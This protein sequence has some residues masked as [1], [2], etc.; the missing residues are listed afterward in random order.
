[1]KLILPSVKFLGMALLMFLVSITMVACGGG[2]GD[3]PDGIIQYTGL[4]S[5][6]LITAGNAEELAT[7]AYLGGYGPA[8][9]TVLD[10]STKPAGGY[11]VLLYLY[12]F[13]ADSV[14]QA[15]QAGAPGVRALELIDDVELSTCPG[16]TGSLAYSLQVNDGTGAFTGSF[17]FYDYCD[18][19][20]TFSG[21]ITVSGV[22][23]IFNIQFTSLS[24]DLFEFTMEI[25]GESYTLDGYV[26]SMLVSPT[27]LEL[28]IDLLLIDGSTDTVYWVNDFFLS[29]T[30]EVFY[31]E[32]EV[33]GTFY[34]PLD[35]YVEL[36]TP[37]PMRFY[38]W[39]N[40]P[41]E[42]TIILSGDEFTSAML[43][44]V[45]S[46]SFIVYADLDGNGSYEW[47][48]GVKFW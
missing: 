10:G 8:Q 2:G 35:G 47:D 15:Y 23:D 34:S 22:F 48:S 21:A 6:A 20:V 45:S 24:L 26:D 16:S 30:E 13:L 11:P 39:D 32:V 14:Q 31:T 19:G 1:M 42:G 29:V 36:T 28:I 12:N 18:A 17:T 4:T 41:S 40:A 9:L 33:S 7:L 44:F 43:E 25:G 46:T 5:P 37:T 27:T 38:D 3:G